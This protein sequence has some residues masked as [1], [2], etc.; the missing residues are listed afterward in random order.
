MR[1]MKSK[2]SLMAALVGIAAMIAMP[3][4]ATAGEHYGNNY[5]NTQ[6]QERGAVIP[7]AHHYGWRNRAN[8]NSNLI[9][10]EDVD[11]NYAAWP[12]ENDD[13]Y[14]SSAGYGDQYYAPS[15]RTRSYNNYSYNSGYGRSYEAP[16]HNNHGYNQPAYRNNGYNQGYG[17]PYNAPY[18]NNGTYGGMSSLAPL[19][20]QFLR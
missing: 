2:Q 18:N 12:D 5:E 6:W 7:A 10:D 17:S 16:A 8:Y 9:C 3:L 19:L 4:A 13:Y 11:D 20:Q 1:Q 15:Y 14:E